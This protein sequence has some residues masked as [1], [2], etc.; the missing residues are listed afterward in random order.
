MLRCKSAVPF[1]RDRKNAQNVGV[2]KIGNNT[3]LYYYACT[4]KTINLAPQ[5]RGFYYLLIFKLIMFWK[6]KQE[7]KK[8]T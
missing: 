7:N 1:G 4:H 5:Y 6:N 2:N 8:S 3:N